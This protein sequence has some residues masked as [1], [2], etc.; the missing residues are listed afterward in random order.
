MFNLQIG[1]VFVP[2]QQAFCIENV[3]Q[4]IFTLQSN[5]FFDKEKH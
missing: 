2:I 3:A 4:L 1:I 5:L